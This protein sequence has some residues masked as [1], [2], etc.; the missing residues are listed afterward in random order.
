MVPTMA[1]LTEM[2]QAVTHVDVDPFDVPNSESIPLD[3]AQ[4]LSVHELQMHHQCLILEAK[5]W[6]FEFF[7]TMPYPPSDAE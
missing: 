5:Q 4:S 7:A 3:I 2:A 1:S 6:A